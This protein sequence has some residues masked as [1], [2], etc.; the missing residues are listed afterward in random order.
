VSVEVKMGVNVG[1]GVKVGEETVFVAGEVD[2]PSAEIVGGAVGDGVK[3]EHEIKTMI[4][5]VSCKRFIEL[6]ILMRLSRFAHSKSSFFNPYDEIILSNNLHDADQSFGILFNLVCQTLKF[7]IAW[8]G[9]VIVMR[10]LRWD[11]ESASGQANA[12]LTM[13]GFI[14]GCTIK[15]L[16]P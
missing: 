5:T 1:V 10:L 4:L 12:L 9:Y 2:V 7:I 6:L 14:C 8:Q 15:W 13:T 11:P 16:S 3:I